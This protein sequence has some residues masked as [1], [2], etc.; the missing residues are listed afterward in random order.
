MSRQFMLDREP[1]AA[2]ALLEKYL[3]HPDALGT[4]GVWCAVGSP[5]RCDWAAIRRRHGRP[6][7]RRKS[8]SPAN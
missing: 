7:R 8:I 5:T 2:V 3:A 1:R 6:T 4:R